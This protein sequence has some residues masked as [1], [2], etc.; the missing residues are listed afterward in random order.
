[1]SEVRVVVVDDSQTIRKIIRHTLAAEPDIEVV[2]EAA[3]A[4]EARSAIKALNPDVITLDVEMPRMSGTEFLKKIMELRPMPVVMLSH[5]TKRGSDVAI[6]ALASGA[7]DCI[8]KPTNAAELTGGAFARELCGSVRMAA[9][10]QVQG[11]SPVVSVDTAPR[12]FRW[13]GKI[14]LIGSSTGG[15]DALERVLTGFPAAAPPTLITQH[16]PANFLRSFAERLNGML[17]L[18]V[19]VGE[20]GMP[21][22]P[23]NVYLAPGGDY[24]MSLRGG[25]N[26]SIVLIDTPP[27]SGHRPSVDVMFEAAVPLAGRV[28]ASVLT[29]MGRDGAEGMAQLR[30]AGARTLCQDAKSSVVYGMPKAAWEKGGVED[31]LGITEMAGALLD[32]CCAKSRTGQNA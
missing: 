7:V 16:M 3:D 18:T 2:G 5:L 25:T 12:E 24:H 1:M 9:N 15:V 14:I 26:P 32:R 30:G 29:G 22:Q 19:Q 31:Q 28:V 17:P 13:N 27:R 10:A 11:R 8:G 20:T 6:E 23:G 21:V 4:Y